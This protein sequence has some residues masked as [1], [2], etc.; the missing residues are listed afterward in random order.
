MYETIIS[1][2]I[3]LMTSLGLGSLLPLKSLGARVIVGSAMTTLLL[4]TLNIFTKQQF[5][6]LVLMILIISIFGIV[7]FIFSIKK[8]SRVLILLH[9]IFILPMI[10]IIFILISENI[11]Y[12]SI[13]WDEFSS[14]LY[15][16]KELYLAD[17][18]LLNDMKWQS[19]KYPQGWPISLSFPQFF[20]ENFDPLRSLSVPLI[21]NIATLGVVYDFTFAYLKKN[22]W[23]SDKLIITVCYLLILFLLSLEVTGTLVAKTFLIE[24]PQVYLLV[25]IFTLVMIIENDTENDFWVVLSIGLLLAL[26]VMIKISMIAAVISVLFPI[27]FLLFG[28]SKGINLN[29]RIRSI[30]IY[31]IILILPSLLIMAFWSQISISEQGQLSNLSFSYDFDTSTLDLLSRI[32]SRTCEYVILWKFPIT[33]FAFII[34]VYCLLFSEFKLIIFGIIIFCLF[35]SF[36]I[37]QLYAFRFGAYEVGELQSLERYLRLPLSLIHFLGITLFVI[38]TVRKL[39]SQNIFRSKK[40]FKVIVKFSILTSLIG[41][42]SYQLVAIDIALFEIQSRTNNSTGVPNTRLSTNN[43]IFEARKEINALLDRSGLKTLQE[44]DTRL[45]TLNIILKEHKEITNLLEHLD[46]KTPN[47]ALIHQG[48]SGYTD[49]IVS[50]LALKNKRNHNQRLLYKVSSGYS[51]GNENIQNIWMR[52]VDPIVLLNSLKDNEV[53]WGFKTD[54]WINDLLRPITSDCQDPFNWRYLVKTSSLPNTFVC[55]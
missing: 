35:Y 43:F 7:K 48:D 54:K 41:I 4:L 20:F 49:R 2:L 26:A 33:I 25:S 16:T 12:Q 47:L 27:V 44:P 36:G 3:V 46:V 51:W 14:W 17:T 21:W 32:V 24:L 45:S 37:L 29:K 53:I 15:W 55:F 18:L 5:S 39:S 6:N 13:D 40:S 19:L 11:S 9:P 1:I 34:L 52:K 10:F 42:F 31:L 8:N 30:S 23:Q 50:F 22:K 38:L 28:K